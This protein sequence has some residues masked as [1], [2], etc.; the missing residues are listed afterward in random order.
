MDSRGRKRTRSRSRPRSRSPSPSPFRS[1]SRGASLTR[2]L[3]SYR[4]MRTAQR[5]LSRQLSG[6]GTVVPFQRTVLSSYHLSTGN[7]NQAIYIQNHTAPFRVLDG[8]GNF[9]NADNYSIVFRPSHFDINW[10]LGTTAVN[11]YSYAMPNFTELT[12]LFDQFQID[13]VEIEWFFSSD[14][15][16]RTDSTSSGPN[17]SPSRPIFGNPMHIY[18]KDYDDAAP[19]SIQSLVQYENQT[20]WQMSGTDRDSR[21]IVRIKP[22]FTMN[23]GDA[24]I[25][26]PTGIVNPADP[27]KYWLDTLNG[28]NIPHYGIKG[29]VNLVGTTEYTSPAATTILG[30]LGFRTTYHYKFKNVR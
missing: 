27:R 19:I 17:G 14:A 7:Q 12:D 6:R 5:L 16:N 26:T 8:G 29:T 10:W 1:A 9:Q 30:C 22:K 18:V 28:V 4:R 11:T 2:D 21:H 3:S 15:V 23:A 13:W 25:G 24:E 20:T